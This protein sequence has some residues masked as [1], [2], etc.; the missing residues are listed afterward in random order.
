MWGGLS[1]GVL[2]C[3]CVFIYSEIT[4]C[5]ISH[6]SGAWRDGEVVQLVGS[7]TSVL[8]D[9]SCA[10]I[11]RTYRFHNTPKIPSSIVFHTR[12][13]KVSVDP[14]YLSFSIGY[15][16]NFAQM[17][18]EANVHHP[19]NRF[20]PL[21]ISVTDNVVRLFKCVWPQLALHLPQCVWQ[22]GIRCKRP[23]HP[24]MCAIEF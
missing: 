22:K 17:D 9:L 12:Q 4:T 6:A 18:C 3:V 21:L 20:F 1:G 14:V 19:M 7:L 10:G 8:T 23:S 15:K 16:S 11:M 2:L 5:F 13:T 24:N